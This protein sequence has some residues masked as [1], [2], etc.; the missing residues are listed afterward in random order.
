MVKWISRCESFDRNF[1]LLVHAIF[2]IEVA[3]FIFKETEKKGKKKKREK[4]VDEML[5]EVYQSVLSQ[6]FVV[7]LFIYS[8]LLFNITCMF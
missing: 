6:F 2:E 7:V 4:V 1:I 5:A 8:L 3:F